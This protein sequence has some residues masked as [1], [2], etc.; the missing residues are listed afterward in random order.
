LGKCSE[1][2][3]GSGILVKRNDATTLKAGGS[4]WSLV[5]AKAWD[6]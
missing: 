5:D 2:W 6:F 3:G 1:A 4:S